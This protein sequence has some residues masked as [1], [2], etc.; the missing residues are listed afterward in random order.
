VPFHEFFSQEKNFE[1]ASFRENGNALRLLLSSALRFAR[2][3]ALRGGIFKGRTAA[4]FATLAY[5]ATLQKRIEW[6]HSLTHFHFHAPAPIPRHRVRLDAPS[7]KTRQGKAEF[8]LR[9]QLIAIGPP[10]FFYLVLG[11]SP[12]RGRTASGQDPRGAGA[13]LQNQKL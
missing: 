10:P 1:Y 4:L 3:S 13:A 7:R 11:N 2:N 8:F 5:C 9:G 12:R 6:P